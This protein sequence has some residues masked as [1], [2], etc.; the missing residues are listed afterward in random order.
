MSPVSVAGAVDG[1]PGDPFL[2]AITDHVSGAIRDHGEFGSSPIEF[3]R[4][5]LDHAECMPSL[6]G[7]AAQASR[8]RASPSRRWVSTCIASDTRTRPNIASRVG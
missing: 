7:V 3:T 6:H 8:A 5:V 2:G 4:F 1:P